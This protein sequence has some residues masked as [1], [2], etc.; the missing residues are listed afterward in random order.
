MQT[1]TRD[2]NS[3]NL[4]DLKNDKDPNKNKS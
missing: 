2:F 1:N 3:Y 4:H